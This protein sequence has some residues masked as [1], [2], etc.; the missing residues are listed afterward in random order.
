MSTISH[1]P[2]KVA[3]EREGWAV[4]LRVRELWAS[5]AITAMWFTVGVTAIWGPDI[6]ASN[7]VAGMG[8]STTIPS[9]VVL[10]LFAL[11]GTWIVA[12]SGF[13]RKRSDD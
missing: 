9:G 10:G 2:T 1:P 7:G 6:T 5:L 11:I 4:L 12:R 8:D 3:P 13:D